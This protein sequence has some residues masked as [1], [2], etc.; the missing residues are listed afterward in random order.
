MN[1][2]KL[3]SIEKDVG[4]LPVVRAL[5]A[6]SVRT[7]GAWCFLDHIGP[8]VLKTDDVNKGLQ[9]GSHPHINLQTFTWM[10]DGKILHRDSLGSHQ[11]ITPN[12]VNLM[13]AGV[14]DDVGICHT[15][16][17]G[18]NGMRLHAVQ[19]WIA[20]P[21]N[22]A[23]QPSFHHYRDL[24]AWHE[25]GIDFILMT[26]KY[27]HY[28]ANPIQYSP[29]VGMDIRNHGA[30]AKPLSIELT[31]GFEYGLFVVQGGFTLNGMHYQQND[32]VKISDFA[33]TTELTITLDAAS[34]LVWIGGEPLEHTV[35]MWWNFV[36]DSKENIQKA[37][38][39]WNQHHPRFGEIDLS[40]TGLT[41]LNSPELP[42]RFKEA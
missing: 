10:L 11:E 34:H 36:G 23:I 13:T 38:N 32:L 31:A 4:G 40:N 28:H 21:L 5:P 27:K 41:R 26:G 7:I 15:E 16:Q 17:S 33:D 39:D 18:E 42:E 37:V 22:Q 14:G 9:V 19:F 29:L 8:T 20:L 2:Q 35:L 30:E 12:Q 6:P 25:S 3:N 24:P 1:I